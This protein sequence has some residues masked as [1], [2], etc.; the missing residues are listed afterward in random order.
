MPFQIVGSTLRAGM[1]TGAL[2]VA[3]LAATPTPLLAQQAVVP[4]DFTGIAR[5]KMPAVV[6]ITTRQRVQ[7]REQAQSLPED[8][9]FREF[10]RRYF[11]EEGDPSQ[12]QSRPRQALGS[13]F[14]IS[15]D[16][17]VI[18]NKHVV[19]DAE[20]IHVV[21][22]ERTNVPARLVGRDPATDI[23]VL[24]VDPPPNMAIVAW[25]DSEAVEPGSWAIAIGSPF[26]L[27][28][29]VTVG[30]VS[31]RSRD[32]QSG[33][34]DDYLQTDA[35]IN[36]GNSGGP[37]FNARGEVI[38][39]NTA[40]FSPSGGNIGIGF[41]VP[42]RTAQAVADQLI[43]AGRVERG[44]V[45]LRLQEITPAIAQAVGRPDGKGALVASVEPGGPAERAGIRSGDVITRFNGQPVESGR[46]L[47][48]AVAALKPGA[49][50]MLTVVRDGKAQDLTVSIGQRQEERVQQATVGGADG[51]RRLGVA[52]APVPEAAR[53]QLGL[54]P[55]ASG[56]LVQQ[57]EPNSPAAE[58]GLRPGDVI[59][60]ANNQPAN[61]PSDVANAWAEA[62]KQKKPIL[63]RV[64]REGQFLFV[65][66]PA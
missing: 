14:V 9:P 56:V 3:A 2:I 53:G 21:F 24:K 46:D 33:P 17:H 30:V 31:A 15:S 19:E 22:G 12:P 45:G 39:V 27:G 48:R 32:I 38:G 40:I 55:G 1:L 29:T 25:G 26:G 11:D 18:T 42:S 37:L 34:Y 20:E 64:R 28:G 50:A 13:G 5:Q 49:Q 57:V 8:L 23:A 63:L 59:V 51:G 4:P 10:F 47:S 52:L 41:A 43:R 58:T 16:G 35:S 62:Q 6:G 36:R 60:S 44:Y 66:V 54:E 61:A 65:A 7:E